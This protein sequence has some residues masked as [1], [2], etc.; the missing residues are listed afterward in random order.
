[1]KSLRT[2]YLIFGLLFIY[3]CQQS[4]INTPPPSWSKSVVWYQIFVERFNNGDTLNDPTPQSMASG[5]WSFPIPADWKITPWTAE[6]Y[7]QEDWA[8]KSG[9]SLKETLQ[10]RRYGGDLQGVINKLDYLKD[11]GI[12]AIY[13]NPLNDAPSLHKYD[14]RN[15]HHI[16]VNF[17]P[18]PIGDA[19]LMLQENP[20]DPS[21]WVWT[22]ADKLFL[23]LIDEVHA[24]GM[25][26]ILD[27]S[28]N[29]TGVEFW[30]W[31]DIL[32]NQEKS[33]YKDWYEITSYDNPSTPE[34][35]FRYKGWLNIESLP[36][37]KKV[38]IVTQRVN[39]QPYEGDINAGAKKHIF[40]V[41]LRWLKPNGDLTKGVDGYRLDVADQIPLGFWRSYHQ[42]V[43][44]INPE[45]FLVGEIWWDSW[46]DK[47]MNPEPYLQGTIF[48]AVMFYQVYK[49]A[50]YFFA[51][52]DHR[53]SAEQFK[54]SLQEEWS[55]ME[56]EF[57]FAQMCVNSTHDTPR[58]LTD[59]YN[60]GKYKFAGY[61]YDNKNYL[62][63]KPDEAT[64][65][66]LRLYLIQQFTSIG[67]PSIYN[68]EE[69]GM[70]GADDPDCRKPLMWPEYQFSTER[71]DFNHSGDG[72]VDSLIFNNNHFNYYK[73]LIEI[74]KANTVLSSG[75]IN[76]IKAKDELLIYSR[77]DGNAV[78]Y[79]A[80]NMSNMPVDIEIPSKSNLVDL[81]SGKMYMNGD[82]TLEPLSGVILK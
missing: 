44:S 74:R 16:D 26:V 21:T 71:H 47:L 19:K 14:A 20:L 52:T 82:V 28:W 18:D 10:H 57:R 30:A 65:K 8:V 32:K 78:I 68:G 46:P 17:G 61:P 60:K 13:L 2:L 54:E 38:N 79:V 3:S 27:Y 55:N 62:S 76:F 4:I 25:R 12:S 40:D 42:Y 45:A 1:M 50:R 72:A 24:R 36:E 5:K 77:S 56:K 15:Y 66:R 37:I 73:K 59:F 7:T 70:W 35:E 31:Q 6:W 11:L 33:V 58:L 67:S 49:P 34:N 64:F 29:H 81:L 75:D 43:K 39:G 51:N 69:M 23:K 63:G 9:K 53:I 80:F 22:A 41:T 48:D